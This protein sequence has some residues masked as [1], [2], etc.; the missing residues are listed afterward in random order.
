MAPTMKWGPERESMRGMACKEIN[1]TG[2][3]PIMEWV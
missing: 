2:I 1:M 3:V